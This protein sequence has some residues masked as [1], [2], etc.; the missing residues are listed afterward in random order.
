MPTF[1]IIIR[2]QTQRRDGTYPVS[3]RLT[4]NRKSANIPTGIYVQRSQVKRNFTGLK[5][6]VLYRHLN[7]DIIKYSDILLKEYGS[8]LTRFT[9]KELANA[10]MVHRA[11][12]EDGNI[13]FVDFCREYFDKLRAEGRG[14]YAM[15]LESTVKNLTHYMGRDKI[16]IREINVRNL[17]GFV[18]YM[19]QPR[20]VKYVDAKGRKVTIE[21][22]G[23]KAQ[24]LKD[25]IA[26]LH[27]LFNLACD[28]YNDEDSEVVLITHNPFRSKK[29]RI[30]VKEQPAKR[31]LQMD[32]LLQI[33]KA[34]DLPMARMQL[35]RDVLLLSF[36]LLAMNTADL[37]GD[38]ATIE[39]GRVLYHRQ[40]VKTRRKDE[41]VFSVKI[42]PEAEA[43][44]E[45][46][47]DTDGER[48]FD[49]YKRY[50]NFRTFNSNV[51]AG[52]KQL[53]KHLG[54]DHTLTTYYMRHSW[55]TIASEDCGISDEEV[56]L[57]L[58]HISADNDVRT[59]KS[60]RVTRGYIHRRFSKNDKNH[61]KV[62]DL[63]ARKLVG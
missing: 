50:S 10:I 4:H 37:Y 21:R 45:K 30:E 7:D 13:D 38:D 61:R 54:W 34:N 2:E 27:T 22:D 24:T 15:R 46:Y 16:G 35:A 6:A 62:L 9:A 59:G 20:K 56:A 55:A 51:N 23:C 11:M 25:Y 57:A 29:L 49:F 58:N 1:T 39:E 19:S 32:E 40:K 53:A 63:L 33:I 26:D 60:L 12:P 18:E 3:I 41:A 28:K 43:L 36:Y 47:R 44:I 5:D 48:L 52:C 31:D 8:D 14:G 42:E 17:Q